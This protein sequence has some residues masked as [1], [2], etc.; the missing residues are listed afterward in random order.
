[1]D[2]RRL[3]ANQIQ[4][5]AET[6]AAS[7]IS[8]SASQVTPAE[9][10]ADEL[11]VG[12]AVPQ[13]LP[14]ATSNVAPQPLI[15]TNFSGPGMTDVS[16]STGSEVPAPVPQPDAGI[17][18]FLD[19]SGMDI[20]QFQEMTDQGI[21]QMSTNF[22]FDFMQL[23]QGDPDWANRCNWTVGDLITKAMDQV[24][25]NP[26]GPPSKDEVIKG[27]SQYYQSQLNGWQSEQSSGTVDSAFAQKNID[28][29]NN[30]LG[31]LNSDDPQNFKDLLHNPPDIIY[32]YNELP[33]SYAP[34]PSPPLVTNPDGS[35][36]V[37]NLLYTAAYKP[38]VHGTDPSSILEKR[39]QDSILRAASTVDV[40]TE[41]PDPGSTKPKINIGSFFRSPDHFLRP[42]LNEIPTP[43]AP[44][45]VPQPDEKIWGPV[46]EFLI[47]ES[48][49]DSTDE[50]AMFAQLENLDPVNRKGALQA[51]INSG[52]FDRIMREMWGEGDE[53]AGA[54][55]RGAA[56]HRCGAD[57]RAQ[58]A[59]SPAVDLADRVGPSAGQRAARVPPCERHRHPGVADERLA[60]PVRYH[61]GG[62]PVCGDIGRRGR[63]SWRSGL[64]GRLGWRRSTA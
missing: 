34:R 58:A 29:L 37:T 8:N 28:W 31:A 39:R 48:A 40:N 52:D 62:G 6:N 49:K 47:E 56:Q 30:V 46:V 45:P 57:A 44:E 15:P 19:E 54:P 36:A 20:Y 2:I 14:E 33:L 41:V 11:Q 35:M 13:W 51:L 60:G 16:S 5:S 23:L 3:G 64:R 26:S 59:R 61:A 53:N 10:S 42:G 12:P 43:D 17:Q 1:M 21:Q 25:K 32:A 24:M 22:G 7:E 38:A 9:Q 27:L 50:D 4:P 63:C 55:D 18:A